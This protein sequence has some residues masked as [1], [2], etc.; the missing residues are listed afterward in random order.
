MAS[1]TKEMVIER[2]V[3]RYAETLGWLAYKFTSPSQRGVPDRMFIKDGKVIFIEFKSTGFKPSKLQN[4]VINK[5]REH[6]AP[7]YIVDNIEQGME[8]FNN[9]ENLCVQAKNNEV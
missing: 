2:T 8:I 5:I 6:G 3:C 4:Y 7:V 1:T 9:F